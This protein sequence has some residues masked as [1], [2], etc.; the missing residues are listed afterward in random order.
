M[1]VFP[2]GT[3]S[4]FEV[5]GDSARF[6]A[7]TSGDGAGRFFADFASS[8]PVN[9]PVEDTMASPSRTQALIDRSGRTA[10]LR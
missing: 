7:I 5:V 4:T 8:V 6:V 9:R 10:Q 3:P 2:A 1:V